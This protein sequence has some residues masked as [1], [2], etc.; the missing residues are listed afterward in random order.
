VVVLTGAGQAFSAGADL[1]Q[2]GQP[3]AGPVL[4][5]RGDYAD[6]L[7]RFTKLGKPV[8]ARVPG[9]AL[10]GGLGLVAS[11]DFAIAGE[12]AVLGTPEIHRGIF[13]MQIMA[14]LERLVPR[15]KLFELMLLGDK[16]DAS[17]A[18]EL[19]LLTRVV[20]DESLDLEVDALARE[21]AKRSPT[22][23]RMGLCAFHEQSGKPLEQ[24]LP[25]LRD[26]LIAVLTSEDAR[27]G[28]KAFAEKREPRWSGK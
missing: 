6:L 22:A 20:P 3:A 11:A 7:L 23:M 25:Y 13:P 24:S 18:L 5:P 14:V 8:I 10:G 17:K 28:L 21:L 15:R 1:S 27:E 16:L 4:A 2:M 12:S 9:P 26:Q 19:G